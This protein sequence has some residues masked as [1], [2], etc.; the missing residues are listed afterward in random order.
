MR[1]NTFWLF[2]T[3]ACCYVFLVAAVFSHNL[4]AWCK[5]PDADGYSYIESL[6]KKPS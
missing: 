5:K 1:R 4:P 6:C 2:A 3:F